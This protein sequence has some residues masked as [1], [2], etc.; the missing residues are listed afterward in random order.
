MTEIISGLDMIKQTGGLLDIPKW[1][2]SAPGMRLA[3]SRDAG[4]ID[5]YKDPNRTTPVPT[6]PASSTL[7]LDQLN[8]TYHGALTDQG[9]LKLAMAVSANYL[10]VQELASKSFN[11]Y[12]NEK[13]EAILGD[14]REVMKEALEGGRFTTFKELQERALA[15]SDEFDQKRELFNDVIGAGD[16]VDAARGNFNKM[17]HAQQDN[18][19]E[20]NLKDWSA[21]QLLQAA[22]N[23]MEF[24]VTNQPALTQALIEKTAQVYVALND[25]SRENGFSNE[26]LS[27]MD[28]RFRVVD[29]VAMGAGSDGDEI[30]VCARLLKDSIDSYRTFSGKDFPN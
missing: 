15:T 19:P 10:A 17:L 26:E 16:A 28:A 1:D 24:K 8:K 21:T 30:S 3:I 5:I 6:F 12:Q 13:K 25:L 29:T 27:L 23:P 18:D 14:L 22:S 11:D 7:S 4:L 9:A 2:H 20:A